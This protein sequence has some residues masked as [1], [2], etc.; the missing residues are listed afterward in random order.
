MTT[1]MRCGF[2]V[3]MQMQDLAA[4]LFPLTVP[5]VGIFSAL[6]LVGLGKGS[7]WPLRTNMAGLI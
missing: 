4:S 6:F 3:L 1:Q 5:A 7:F 2:M